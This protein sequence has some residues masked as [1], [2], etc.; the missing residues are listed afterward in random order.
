M[1]ATRVRGL[2]L[3]S[4]L[5]LLT[6]GSACRGPSIP[7]AAIQG[8]GA[9]VAL[10][11]EEPGLRQTRD[12]ESGVLL[13]EWFLERGP[14][15]VLVHHGSERLWFPDGR[16]QAE[17]EFAHG[18]PTGRWRTYYPDGTP[19]SD[20]HFADGGEAT[21]WHPNGQVSAQGTLR[22]G[23]KDGA[24]T[25]WYEDGTKA[26]EGTYRASQRHGEWSFWANDGRLRA[27]GSYEDDRRVG[28]WQMWDPDGNPVQRAGEGITAS[29]LDSDRP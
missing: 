27:R 4:G 1:S 10:P 24:W 28:D 7:E 11:T 23:L 14:D 2:L 25:Y 19:R 29:E 17:R 9:P 15:G 20:Q 21:W 5:A 26:E 13:H 6:G 22:E 3:A 16:L 8:L 12:E 18:E